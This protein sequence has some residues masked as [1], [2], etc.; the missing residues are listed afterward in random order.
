V[1]VVVRGVGAVMQG[2]ATLQQEHTRLQQPL[3]GGQRTRKAVSRTGRWTAGGGLDGDLERAGGV[4]GLV[5]LQR[6]SGQ[7]GE[8]TA[9]AQP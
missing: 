1:C 2:A 9:H 8:A 6:F 5:S 3:L 4:V 7:M